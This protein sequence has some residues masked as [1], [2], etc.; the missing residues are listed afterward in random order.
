MER[1]YVYDNLL[2]RHAYF[3]N[4]I[5]D[6]SS[7]G[8]SE[9]PSSIYVD[10]DIKVKVMSDGMCSTGGGSASDAAFDGEVNFP[11]D[12]AFDGCEFWLRCRVLSDYSLYGCFIPITPSISCPF[13]QYDIAKAK[14]F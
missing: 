10:Q 2:I 12:A 6:I 8:S 7:D 11:I 3:V 1:P 4:M 13:C 5:T 9:C 14:L